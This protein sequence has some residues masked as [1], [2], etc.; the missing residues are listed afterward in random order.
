[1]IW[2]NLL[3]CAALFPSVTANS[4]RFATW[5]EPALLAC[6][7]QLLRIQILKR[8][9]SFATI[10]D[11]LNESQVVES[12]P[13]SLIDELRAAQPAFMAAPFWFWNDVIDPQEVRR[14]IV[15]MSRRNIGGF[16]MHARMGRVTPYMSDGWMA[17]VKAAVDEA[18]QRGLSAWIYDEDGWPSGYGGGAVNALGENYLQQ[19]ATAEIIPCNGS[20]S[21]RLE[22]AGSII[23]AY[24]SGKKM[25][26]FGD[27]NRLD[28]SD[29]TGSWSRLPATCRERL[30]IFRRELHKYRRHFSPEAWADGYVDVLNPEVTRAFIREIYEA[31]RREIGQ[32]FGGTVPGVFTDEPSYHELG[33][34]EPVVRLP[35]SPV[36]EREFEKRY[37][38]PLLDNLMTIAFG[39][40]DAIR[41][42]WCF[43]SSLAYLFAHNYTRILAEWCDK[44]GIV[45]TGHYLLEEHPRC[46]THV[47]GDP[48]LHYFH[49]QY[50][51]ID[52]L[53]KDLDLKDFWSSARVLV[54]QASSI[55][56]QFDK[57]R[58][59]CE[60]FAG[61]GWHFGIREQKWMADWQYAMGLNL[62]CQHAF[63]YS[64]RGFRKRDYPPSLSFQQPWWPFSG[65]LGNHF[66]RLGYLLTRG[67]RVVNV[68]VMHPIESF[69]ATHEPG[70]YPWP[71][72]PL[73]ESLKKLVACLLA[74]Q[75]DFDFG[76]E[77]LLKS[78]GK[79]E[80][81]RITIGSASY[82]A[83]IVPH[84]LT[85]RKSTLSALRRFVSGGGRL[86]FVE[87]I[88]THVEGRP[89]GSYDRLLSTAMNLG[90][91][92]APNFRDCVSD[93]VSPVARPAC[94]LL[95]TDPHNLDVMVMH[96]QTDEHDIFFLASASKTSHTARVVFD[97]PGTPMLLDTTTG[98]TSPMKHTREGG[99]CRVDLA[100]DFARSFPILFKRG[101]KT[102]VPPDEK[103]TVTR[104]LCR[105]GDPIE[106]EIDR[107]NALILDRGEL[108]IKGASVGMMSTL[109]AEQALA[110]HG[111]EPE[112]FLRFTAVSEIAVPDAALV[113]ETPERFEIRI[114]G[115][116]VS[117]PSETEWVVDP[118]FRRI[119]IPDGIK[120]GEN[121]VEIHFRWQSG[122]EIE[123]MYLLGRFGA[124]VSGEKCRI[125][126]LPERLTVGSWHDQGLAFYAGSVTYHMEVE[127]DNRASRWELCCP[128]YHSSIQV[129]VNGV[130]A[131]A[132]LWAPHRL[133]L[134]AHLKNGHNHIE[135]KVAN[136]LRNFLG[137]HH[138]RNEDEIDCLGPHNFFNTKQ[139]VPEYRFKPAGLL[140]EV[141]LI[142]Y[143]K[144]D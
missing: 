58:V 7:L 53:G 126:A 61:G 128:H 134:T 71:N 79:I 46:A 17:A 59:M 125:T 137:P 74:H 72:D 6:S 31:Y 69:F 136:C 43:Y 131:G 103:Q 78:H 50:P 100:F 39:G 107:D 118:C 90:H 27:C 77:V 85:W 75:I 84:S 95:G 119:P 22:Q 130:E 68:L 64:L 66:A 20:V 37:G 73:N 54:K 82:D 9:L 62:V 30:V 80:G 96:R 112:A 48:M 86:Y 56:H 127:I 36:L 115:N 4:C 3:S 33:W 138:L 92:Q 14:Q 76:N 65:D 121:I 38:E 11:I 16:F 106:F 93:L 91:W 1:M 88:P 116:T 114:N 81:S 57:P 2:Y 132:I 44:H 101:R 19:Y 52:H 49:Q 10:W 120:A 139:R 133:D 141:S 124:Y 99:E 5:L 32:A 122:L 29:L 47:I 70:G 35:M 104:R 89:S 41:A 117:L 98:R 94:R 21:P 24:A 111:N 8:C 45:F 83:V 113:L 108:F 15:E 135:L 102:L 28:P 67:R 60:T 51:G 25:N 142:G 143:R 144:S 140:G 34:S 123:P 63:H 18:R 23:A 40:P 110:Q 97:A 129:V 13:L 55:A 26:G 109:D 12:V 105:A 42:R 87:P